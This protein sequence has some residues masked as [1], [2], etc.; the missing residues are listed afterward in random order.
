MGPAEP[1]FRYSDLCGTNNVHSSFITHFHTSPHSEIPPFF[2]P[3][4]AFS[5]YGFKFAMAM[6]CGRESVCDIRS[7]VPLKTF[8]QVNY[9]RSVQCLQFSSGTLGKEVLVFV[10]VRLT[11]TF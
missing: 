9:N 2:P 10:E 6:G 5:A 11:Y 7:K 1:D 8:M 4:L 3:T